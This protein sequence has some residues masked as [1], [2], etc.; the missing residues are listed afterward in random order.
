MKVRD[1]FRMT[2]LAYRSLL[3]SAIAYGLRKAVAVENEQ[4]R[5]VV[6]R[7]EERAKNKD[8]TTN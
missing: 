6:E 8:L 4:T 3:E 1:E 7:D 5:S 2:I